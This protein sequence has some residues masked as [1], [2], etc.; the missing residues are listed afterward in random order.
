MRDHQPGVA[1]PLVCRW[2]PVGQMHS[3]KPRLKILQQ[4]KHVY[5]MLINH[6][7]LSQAST[8]FT[9]NC[10]VSSVPV[11]DSIIC[12]L[13]ATVVPVKGLQSITSTVVWQHRAYPASP[14]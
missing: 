6:G 1:F 8:V 14:L 7:F 3:H 13:S 2:K 10:Q 5:C 12:G 11:S 9:Q 4:L